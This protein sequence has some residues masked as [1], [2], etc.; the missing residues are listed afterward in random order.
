ML[1]YDSLESYFIEFSSLLLFK[2]GRCSHQ[3]SGLVA[4]PFYKR[5]LFNHSVAAHAGPA[6]AVS[7]S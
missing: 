4:L 6:A 5:Y 2:Q 7:N 3:S 1:V